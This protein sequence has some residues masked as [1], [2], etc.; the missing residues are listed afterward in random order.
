MY[1]LCVNLNILPTE[2]EEAYET[3]NL[4]LC[5]PLPIH[6]KLILLSFK[7]GLFGRIMH[8]FVGESRMQ[9][10]QYKQQFL[11]VR[12]NYRKIF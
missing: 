10:R 7:N 12:E 4:S 2:L 5:L 11:A 6:I 9:E 8:D 3:G 1:L